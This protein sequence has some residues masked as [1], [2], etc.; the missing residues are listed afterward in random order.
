M[1]LMNSSK[2]G[3]T[4]VQLRDKTKTTKEL[5]DTATRL[6]KV[7]RPAGVPL[8]VNDRVGLMLAML[9]SPFLIFVHKQ[10]ID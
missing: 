3:A 1:R 8:I 2:G 5:I 10:S 6:L 7:T 4:I 9:A